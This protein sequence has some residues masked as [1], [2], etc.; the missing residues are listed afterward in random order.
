MMGSNGDDMFGDTFNVLTAILKFKI[1]ASILV[2]P[3][4]TLL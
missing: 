3:L 4:L 2:I 1:A